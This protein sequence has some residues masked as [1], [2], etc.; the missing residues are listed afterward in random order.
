MRS[1][2]SL[3]SAGFLSGSYVPTSFANRPSRGLVLSISHYSIKRSL[4]L[5]NLDSRIVSTKPFLRLLF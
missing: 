3:I 5:A 2:S 1:A 4:L